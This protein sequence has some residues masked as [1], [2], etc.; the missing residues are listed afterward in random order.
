MRQRDG[1][2]FCNAKYGSTCTICLTDSLHRSSIPASLWA[3]GILLN[4]IT[5]ESEAVRSSCY[6]LWYM[7]TLLTLKTR[8]FR[9]PGRSRRGDE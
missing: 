8:C 7:G 3:L 2:A 6:L 4:K 9:L 1:R 5:L